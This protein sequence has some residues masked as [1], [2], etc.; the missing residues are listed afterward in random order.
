M[1]A[2]D[3]VVLVV[4]DNETNLKLARE[5]LKSRGYTVLEALDGMAGLEM[6]REHR[7]NLILLDI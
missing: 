6:A 2:A 4:E 7:P 1:T 3:Q 5:L